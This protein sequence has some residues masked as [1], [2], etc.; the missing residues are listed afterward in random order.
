MTKDAEV[1]IENAWNVKEPRLRVFMNWSGLEDCIRQLLRDYKNEL[2][3][4]DS[5]LTLIDDAVAAFTRRGY[6]LK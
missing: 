1:L 3:D 5:C 6:E 2:R 4:P